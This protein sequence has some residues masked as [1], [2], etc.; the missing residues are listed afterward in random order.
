MKSFQVGRKTVFKSIMTNGLK[1]VAAVF[2]TGKLATTW[3]GV[4]SYE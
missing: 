4:K 3:G 1:A 2:P